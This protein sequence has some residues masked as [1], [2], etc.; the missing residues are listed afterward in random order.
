MGLVCINGGQG[1][2]IN[3]PWEKGQSCLGI[4]PSDSLAF[5][6]I[7][8]CSLLLLGVKE[9]NYDGLA[10]KFVGVMFH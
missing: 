3:V 10:D 7:A 2:G 1:G 8:A 6:S 5:R 9:G 4:G